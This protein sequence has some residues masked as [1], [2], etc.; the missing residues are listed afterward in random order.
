M[1]LTQ[2]KY[3]QAAAKHEHITKA[4]AELHVAQPALTKAVH[5]LEEE[6][7]VKLFVRNGRNVA[8]SR[9][10]E[11]LMRRLTPILASLD[12]IPEELQE[13]NADDNRTVRLRLLSGAA[14]TAKI[15]GAY[16]MRQQ[17]INFKLAQDPT[18]TV[19]IEITSRI[20][21]GGDLTPPYCDDN[22]YTFREAILL[23][24][25]TD[26]KYVGLD[27]VPLSVVRNEAFVCLSSTK[28][29][30][31]ICDEFCRQAGFSPKVVFESDND[32][33]VMGL[34][35]AGGYLSF[36]P[37]LTWERFEGDRVALIP[38]SEPRCA[39]EL[40]VTCHADK[41]S[42]SAARGFFE[43]MIGQLVALQNGNP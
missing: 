22:T 36:W 42:P 41:G 19:D 9:C 11:E 35:I 20:Y 5:R 40:I 15:V 29:F 39:R 32:A 33:S 24:V 7:G 31:V 27:C 43:Y 34:V 8:L 2:L 12:T 16:K 30:R 26:S 18:R 25:S 28:I 21:Q 1:E 37:E 13:L 4:A 14:M 10:G 3:F 17:N 23:A 38:I 6:L